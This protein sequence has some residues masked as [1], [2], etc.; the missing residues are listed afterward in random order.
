MSDA[1]P[2]VDIKVSVGRHPDPECAELIPK[3]EAAMTLGLTELETELRQKLDA[4]LA[5][6]LPTRPPK[7]V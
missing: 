2:K 1:L 5:V 4:R 6:W 7:K 3:I